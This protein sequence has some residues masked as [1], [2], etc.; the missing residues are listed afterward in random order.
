MTR[1]LDPI[2]EIGISVARRLSE[3]LSAARTKSSRKVSSST[4]STH[5]VKLSGGSAGIGADVPEMDEIVDEQEPMD[6]KIARLDKS[7]PESS[8]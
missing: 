6:D 5:V 2:D 7:P 1:T 4:R 8:E 3:R